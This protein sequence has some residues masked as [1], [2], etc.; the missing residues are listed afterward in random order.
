M[1]DIWVNPIAIGMLIVY[2]VYLNGKIREC[3][4]HFKSVPIQAQAI[5]QMYCRSMI[6]LKGS[7]W[8][9]RSNTLYIGQGVIATVIKVECGTVTLE[10]T[11]N[12]KGYTGAS[13]NIVEFLRHF[14]LSEEHL[15]PES[16]M[17]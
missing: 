9:C 11:D 8:K 4:S 1:L 7:H 12:E 13:I 6:P 15:Q 16:D 17:K 14:Q 3:I 10:Y 5:A 2:C